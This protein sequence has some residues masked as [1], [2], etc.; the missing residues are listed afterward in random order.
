MPGDASCLE[1]TCCINKKDAETRLLWYTLKSCLS[2][3]IIGISCEKTI[4]IIIM[5]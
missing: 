3:I 5:T 4:K 2:V 1:E